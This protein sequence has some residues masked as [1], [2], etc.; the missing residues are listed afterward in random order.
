MDGLPPL[1]GGDAPKFVHTNA[2]GGM[3]AYA[4]GYQGFAEQH[5]EHHGN[6]SGSPPII[7]MPVDGRHNYARLIAEQQAFNQPRYHPHRATNFSTNGCQ[8][9]PFSS[10]TRHPSSCSPFAASPQ[11]A[12]MPSPFADARAPG[13]VPRHPFGGACFDP[14]VG[15]PFGGG[16]SRSALLESPGIA[17]PL[18]TD[19]SS[20]DPLFN[21]FGAASLPFAFAHQHDCQGCSSVHP[22]ILPLPP[23]YSA[24]GANA[25]TNE[26]RTGAANRGFCGAASMASASLRLPAAQNTS[27]AQPGAVHSHTFS[28]LPSPPS[29]PP[30]FPYHAAGNFSASAHAGGH[31]APQF[32][33]AQAAGSS[34]ANFSSASKERIRTPSEI[35]AGRGKGVTGGAAGDA[36]RIAKA[37]EDAHE[38]GFPVGPI[39]RQDRHSLK[40]LI[41][42]VAS[43]HTK[44]GG[45]WGINFGI[46]DDPTSTGT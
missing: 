44:G 23:L 16:P 18:R 9:T 28:H 15:S 24:P 35:L 20:T 5:E 13:F 37:H 12:P 1:Q 11:H 19:L 26:W 38:A 4:S 41:T 39:L 40:R 3:A 29:Q 2:S 36:A 25:G 14:A 33:A 30:M 6:A 46:T 27:S 7:Q 43:D 31:S 10:A 32:S 21:T 42:S 45:A 17:A 22:S 8:S 34:A